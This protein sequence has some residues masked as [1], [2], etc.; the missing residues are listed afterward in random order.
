MWPF[1]YDTIRIT[2]L[3]HY[4]MSV[5]KE[6]EI[7]TQSEH[8]IQRSDLDDHALEVVNKLSHSGYSA[9]LVGGC[10]RDL[11][12][13]LKPKD[14]DVVTDATPNQV[15][16]LFSNCNVIGRRFR[17]AQVLFRKQVVQVAT[18]RANHSNDHR[19]KRRIKRSSAGKILDDNF[20]GRSIGQDAFR[21]DLTMNALYLCPSDMT[22]VDYTGGLND[23]RNR[24]VRV[25]GDAPERYR[26]D[27]VRMLRTIR[28]AASLD[29]T[30]DESS[31]EPIGELSE[32]L[33]AVSNAR[34]ADELAK[35]FFN[36]HAE[37]TFEL[38]LDH[39]LFQQLFPPYSQ[40]KGTGIDE[41]ALRWLYQLFRETDARRPNGET[42]SMVYFL[43]AILW[44]PLKNATDHRRQRVRKGRSNISHLIWD[45]ID[46]Q[47][48]STQINAVQARRIQN[49]WSLQRG[50]ESPNASVRQIATAAN[51]RPALRLLE[52]RAK[53]GEVNSQITNRWVHIRN[54]QKSA[55]NQRV[56]HRRRRTTAQWT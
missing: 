56:R 4:K 14:Y 54:Q 24:T 37:A 7:I 38:L 1:G 10:V 42:L 48:Q 55:P 23:I 8:G 44:F 26:E 21:R 41:N 45:I 2:P 17:L 11:L 29:F 39:G 13:G 3:R 30:I 15:Q 16:R 18:Y 35:L 40:S 31:S 12:L 6:P 9:Q 28:F 36:N 19:L 22:I 33:S 53:S 27:P 52:L 43:A 49:I 20:Y 47:D 34:L 46:L 50:L 25:I 32:L 5:A 51:F